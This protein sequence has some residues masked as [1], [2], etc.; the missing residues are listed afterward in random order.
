MD[1]ETVDLAVIGAGKHGTL[2]PNLAF[3]H[4]LE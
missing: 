3:A 4:T 2:V 1:T